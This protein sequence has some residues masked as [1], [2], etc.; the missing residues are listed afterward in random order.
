MSD[1][2]WIVNASPLILFGK[3]GRTDLLERL[4]PRVWVPEAVYREVAAGPSDV[5]QARALK[6]AETRRSEDV[7]VPPT[8]LARDL[9]AGES[10]VL[11]QG[12]RGHRLVVLDDAEARAA[13]KLAS[14]PVIGSLGVLLR[15][16]QAGWVPEVR[17]LVEQL[18][19]CGSWLSPALIRQALAKVGE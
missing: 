18:V 1:P 2:D 6:F 9:G 19:Q 8:I 7:P 3:L 17:P 14:L 13:A 4:A 15:A 12:L 11:A 5:G 16:K 10:Q